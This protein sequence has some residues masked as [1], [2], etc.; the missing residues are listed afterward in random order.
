M[1]NRMEKHQ[2]L[3]CGTPLIRDPDGDSDN[4]FASIVCTKCEEELKERYWS[5]RKKEGQPFKSTKK[6][7]FKLGD[8]PM[9]F[10]KAKRA[11][12]Q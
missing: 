4:P 1:T 7:R 10:S 9:N 3:T 8:R 6:L 12:N 5:H 2:C 11:L